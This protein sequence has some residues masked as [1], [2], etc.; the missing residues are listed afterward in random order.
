MRERLRY[1]VADLP[2]ERTNRPR[3]AGLTNFVEKAEAELAGNAML[4]GGEIRE[5]PAGK[6]P[7]A[8][9]EFRG[10]SA[11][12]ACKGVMNVEM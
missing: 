5:R 6:G 11:Y 1:D 9:K 8:G 10:C 2:P 7:S 3:L 12:P 4:C